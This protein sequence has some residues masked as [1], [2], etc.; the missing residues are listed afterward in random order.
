[1]TLLDI[2]PQNVRW[3]I[4]TH[5]HL[6]HAGG[7]EYFPNS[8][9]LVSH[10]EYVRPYGFVEGVF[11]AW[12]KP[13]LI[14]HFDH[15]GGVFGNGHV[16]TT[17]GDVIIVPTPGHTLNH[18]SVIL[19]TPGLDLFFAGDASFNTADM[20][21]GFVPGIN[22]DRRMARQTLIQIR[23]YCASTPTVFLPSHDQAAVKNFFFEG[24]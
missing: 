19:K 21:T 18:Q 24:N 17:A 15:I 2:S 12:F 5:L 23:E 6:D 20:E 22:V 10:M 1:M 11:P 8:E 16:L 7:I 14:G 4:L 9:I 3:V 13:N